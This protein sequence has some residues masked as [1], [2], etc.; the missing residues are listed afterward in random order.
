MKFCYIDESGAGSEPVLVMAG[1]VTDAS[2]MHVT[3]ETWDDF[4]NLLSN[5]CGRKIEEFHSKDFYRGNSQWRNIRGDTR[6]KI[7]SGI[8]GWLEKRKHAIAFTAIDKEKYSSLCSDNSC[9]INE[10][11]SIWCAAAFHL[12]MGIQK[13]HQGE[14]KNKGNTVFVFDREVMHEKPLTKLV[15][16]PP[17]WSGLFYGEEGSQLTQVVDVPFF[18]DSKHVLLIQ[19]ADLIAYIIRLYIELELGK[20][21]EKFPGE[22]ERFASWFTLIKSNSLPQASRW[23]TKNRNHIHDNFCSLAPSC[24]LR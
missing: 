9:V 21:T 5:I 24:L 10:L 17:S 7:I 6:H 4:L 22:H 12:I 2:R 14:K 16:N 18:A 11:G 1:I 20:V 23:P 3:K 19:V 15:C 8:L 13:H